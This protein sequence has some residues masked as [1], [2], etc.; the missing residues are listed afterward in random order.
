METYKEEKN[1]GICGFACVGV[2]KSDHRHSSVMRRWKH[3]VKY[4]VQRNP[5]NYTHEIIKKVQ[6]SGN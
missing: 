2:E 5:W 1:N 3:L 4:S 6:S